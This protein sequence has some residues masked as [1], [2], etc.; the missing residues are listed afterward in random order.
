[1]PPPFSMCWLTLAH[2]C[3]AGCMSHTADC[4][5]RESLQHG[6]PT[7]GVWSPHQHMCHMCSAQHCAVTY[8]DGLCQGVVHLS[9]AINGSSTHGFARGWQHMDCKGKEQAVHCGYGWTVPHLMMVLPVKKVAVMPRVWLRHHRVLSNVRF[10]TAI[11]GLLTLV[12]P[13]DPCAAHLGRCMAALRI[14]Q[15]RNASL[16]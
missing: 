4:K 12:L 11:P 7:S 9:T 15:C 8:L 5:D 6:R 3:H 1:M 14:S 16:L 2:S 10:F 13:A